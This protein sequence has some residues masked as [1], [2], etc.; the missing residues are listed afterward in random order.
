MTETTTTT[1]TTTSADLQVMLAAF[2]EDPWDLVTAAAL[3]DAAL[4]ADDPGLAAA[5]GLFLDGDA[6]FVLDQRPRRHDQDGWDADLWVLE[7]RLPGGWPDDPDWEGYRASDLLS[8]DLSFVDVK[9]RA[10]FQAY[11]DDLRRLAG[12]DEGRLRSLRRLYETAYS[13]TRFREAVLLLL[14]TLADR[15][16]DGPGTTGLEGDGR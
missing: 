1:T 4:E 5:C 6:F 10:L 16:A 12:E 13:E 2:T 8:H 3:R 14:R 15:L 7:T 11:H 9:R